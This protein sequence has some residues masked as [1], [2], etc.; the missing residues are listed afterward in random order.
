MKDLP[1]LSR[2]DFKIHGGLISDTT[3]EISY[4]SICKQIDE[5][6]KE[7]HTSNEVIRGVLRAIKPGNFRDMLTIKT[8][9]SQNLKSSCSPT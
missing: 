6:L 7:N 1:L 5:G 4:N 2:K 9:Q 8:S 3:S